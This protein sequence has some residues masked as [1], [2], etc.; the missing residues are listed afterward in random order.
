MPEDNADT[1]KPVGPFED[2]AACVRHFEDDDQVDDPDA[3][4]GW[5]EENKE[6]GPVQEYQPSEDDVQDLVEAMKEP[7]AD[8]VLTDLEVTHVS[9]VGDP[10]QDS[11]WVMAKA[12]DDSP[13]DWGVTAPLVFTKDHPPLPRFKAEI[14]E[15]YHMPDEEAAAEAAA[16]LGC[17]GAHQHDDGTWMPC[18]SHTSLVGT[19][20]EAGELEVDSAYDDGEEQEM[21]D[22]AEDLDDA[23]WEGYV[24][25]GLK[26]DPNGDGMVPDCVPE[27]SAQA[28]AAN[29]KDCGCREGPTSKDAATLALQDGP[30]DQ[31]Q[32]KAWAPVLIPNETDKQGDVIPAEAIE[33][34]AHEFLSEYRNIDT[35]HDLLEGKGVPVES[36]TLKEESTFTLPDGSESRPYPKGTWMMGV[37]FSDE[38][39]DRVKNGDLTGFSIYGEATEHSVQDL[40]GGGMEVGMGDT[41]AQFR[42]TAKE[43]AGGNSTT[44]SMTDPEN[45]PEEGHEQEAQNGAGGEQ[46]DEGGEEQPTLKEIQ[47]TVESTH[48]SVQT[49]QEK[50]A[51]H[52]D[53]LESL[54]SEVFEEDEGAEG[55]G[56]GQGG[57]GG[58][59][60]GGEETVDA[61]AVAEQAAEAATEEA[62]AE[63]KS[64]LGLDEDEDLPEDREERQEVVRKHIHEPPEQDEGTGDPGAWTEE[65]ISEVLE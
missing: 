24:A 60:G 29:A 26:P 49:V 23:C 13:A 22:P 43:T 27:D 16:D 19:L 58:Q 47:D 40:L 34:A 12:T 31:A 1:Q 61:D 17:A 2:H 25:V 21:Q 5:M 46:P 14:P 37:E 59:A 41:I 11:Q 33:K 4:C 9:G 56:G 30:A 62:K 36:W 44:E 42:A 54:E 57:E 64:L 7:T 15:Q 28:Q 39:W 45:D 8:T 35:D 10:A 3:L 50:Q 32:R 53:R 52:A 65:E 55:D 20:V 6:V 63:V 51:D 48:E 18:A 38:T